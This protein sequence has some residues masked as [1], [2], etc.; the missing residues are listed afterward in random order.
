MSRSP[1]SL[2]GE[3]R[4]TRPDGQRGHWGW[5]S[6][7]ARP[8]APLLPMRPLGGSVSA[9]AL[10]ASRRR[11]RRAERGAGRPAPAPGRG[12]RAQA[13]VR[14]GEGARGRGAGGARAAGARSCCPPLWAPRLGRALPG[15]RLLP[16]GRAA[17]PSGS[18]RDPAAP[19]LPTGPR[20]PEWCAP[21]SGRGP[22]PR[23]SCRPPARRLWAPRVPAG[24]GGASCGDSFRWLS[25]VWDR[26]QAAF[27]PA[28]AE[29][30]LA[31]QGVPRGR[32]CPQPRLPLG[33]QTRDKGACVSGA[34]LPQLALGSGNASEEAA[35][36]V[37]GR[38]P[39]GLRLGV[40][41]SGTSCWS[42]GC[43]VNGSPDGQ[44]KV[45]R[46]VTLRGAPPFPQVSGCCWLPGGGRGAMAPPPSFLLEPSSCP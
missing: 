26:P 3:R 14:A 2:P 20:A 21:G 34:V 10:P 6:G 5:R 16:G 28:W 33:Q 32:C 1:A 38:G 12:G 4:D 23:V 36:R 31:L 27:R 9:Q 35:L 39:G 45:R 19:D 41:S 24:E 18:S 7:P 44:G 15:W 30:G 8:A 42:K 25:W 40:G 29:R 43:G 17:G 22:G 37:R 11:T 46:V 13:E